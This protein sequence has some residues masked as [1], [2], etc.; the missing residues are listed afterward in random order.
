MFGTCSHTLDLGLQHRFPLVFIMAAVK[1]PVLGVDFLQYYELLADCNVKRWLHTHSQ[2]L[3]QGVTCSDQSMQLTLLSSEPTIRY[4]EAV[5]RDFPAVAQ[6]LTDQVPVKHNVT[7][8]ITTKGP[9]VHTHTRRLPLERLTIARNE[10][11]HM[12]KF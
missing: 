5:L 8:H 9:P 10:F 12:F 4:E 11:D 1:Q 2:S 3:V 6:P 7:P